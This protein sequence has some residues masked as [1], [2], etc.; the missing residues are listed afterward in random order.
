M[1]NNHTHQNHFSPAL[2]WQNERKMKWMAWQGSQQE[3]ILVC[4]GRVVH[5][6]RLIGRLQIIVNDNDSHSFACICFGCIF[7]NAPGSAFAFCLDQRARPSHTHTELF[8]LF[9]LFCND[10]YR[11]ASTMII[12]WPR[13]RVC[14]AHQIIIIKEYTLAETSDRSRP[15]SCV[16][17]KHRVQTTNKSSRIIS[18]LWVRRR[19][20][21]IFAHIYLL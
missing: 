1:C 12:I 6:A 11:V 13:Q 19:V 10:T 16:R 20:H 21:N 15:T 9:R 2:R 17:R 8:A 18:S 4:S 5:D 3:W 14:T 7:K